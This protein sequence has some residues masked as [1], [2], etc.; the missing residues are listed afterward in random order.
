VIFVDSS[1]WIDFLRNDPTPEADRLKGLIGQV[2]LL[3]GDIILC[4]VLQG[5]PTERQALEVE[6]ALRRF[7][8]VAVVDDTVAV[9]AAANYRALRVRGITIRKTIDM[10]I[11][12]FCLL[13]GH[14]LLHR[15]RDF[16]PMAE[17]LGL[18][19]LKV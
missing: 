17:Y 3:V 4:E 19:V 12:T 6:A 15:D 16:D 7:E 10:L 11:G 13:N 1:V 8:V 5:V 18:S 14:T 2:P 9:Q